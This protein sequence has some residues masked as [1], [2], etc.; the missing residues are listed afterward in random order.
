MEPLQ[1]NPAR[2]KAISDEKL[3]KLWDDSEWKSQVKL[4][5][6]RELLHFGGDLPRVFLTGR[7]VS[8]VTGLLSEKALNVPCLWPN[9]DLGYTVLDGEVMPPDGAGFRDMAS[10]LNADPEVAAETIE[11]LGPPIYRVFDVLFHDGVDVR[12]YS[13]LERSSLCSS[14]ADRLSNP[15]ITSVP[16]LPSSRAEYER[17]VAAGGEGVILKNIFAQYGDT[18][19]WKKVKKYSTLDVIVT[20]FTEAKFGRTGKYDGQIGA[21]IVSVFMSDGSM[22]EV[23]QVSGMDDA[24]RLEMTANPGRWV[25]T[26]IEVAAQEFG[27]QRLRHPRFKRHRVDANPRDATY[28]KMMADLGQDEQRVVSGDQLDL[29]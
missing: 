16:L 25:G 12:E 5:G 3:E 22:C 15:L 14:I 1:L 21:A 9:A 13:Q 18:S 26:V 29:F 6:W 28:R 20:G 2:A 10:I 23:G 4:D 17:I 11:R 19:A 7:R 27:K 8:S 24:T